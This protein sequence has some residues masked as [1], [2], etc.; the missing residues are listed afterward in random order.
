MP[1]VVASTFLFYGGGA[2]GLFVL[3]PTV[4]RILLSMGTEHLAPQIAVGQLLGFLLQLV[5]ACGIVFQLPLVTTYLTIAGILTPEFLLARWRHAVLVIFVVAAVVTPG[6]GPSQLVLGIPVT[7]LYFGSVGLSFLVRGKRKVAVP[8]ILATPAAAAG[9]VPRS[10]PPP[11]A[12]TAAAEEAG[13]EAAAR[14]AAAPE[15]SDPPE[16]AP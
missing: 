16:A 2:F 8:A 15:G 9:N 11:A 6:D 10:L 4:I 7:V 12:P 14:E 5:L 13:R 1:G 3:V